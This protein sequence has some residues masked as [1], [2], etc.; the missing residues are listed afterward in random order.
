[1][2][3]RVINN[4][5]RFI[6]SS[7]NLFKNL[8]F[9]FCFF[10]GLLTRWPL[11]FQLSQRVASLNTS[12]HRRYWLLLATKI[13][14]SAMLVLLITAP[15]FAANS[16]A[17]SADLAAVSTDSVSADP[18]SVSPVPNYIS[19]SFTAELKAYNRL[20]P[21]QVNVSLVF[22]SPDGIR[23]QQTDMFGDRQQGWFLQSFRDNKSWV[24][25]PEKR[26]YA[27]L[28]DERQPDQSNS[29]RQDQS[30]QSSGKVTNGVMST[31]VCAGNNLVHKQVIGNDLVG[32]Y[33]TVIV[34]CRYTQYSVRQFFSN[35][36][37]MVLKEEQ[38]GN[39]IVELGR[40]E[41]LVLQ[42]DLYQPPEKF[43]EV[44]LD[45]FFLRA[46]TLGRFKE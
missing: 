16:L 26:V 27:E 38:P 40:I 21:E 1:M 17:V 8:P 35:K 9:R 41:E 31:Q 29:Q 45:E 24:V 12:S 46:N 30:T 14:P 15:V 34:A 7:R 33:E 13:T 42:N 19:R 11:S 22:I 10:P 43:A 2:N 5:F 6:F 20:S 28:S 18:T 3:T 32:G 25:R 37:N 23:L 44:S 36:L 4:L 39:V